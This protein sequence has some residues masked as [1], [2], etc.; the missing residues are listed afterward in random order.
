MPPKY[1]ISEELGKLAQRLVHLQALFFP[2]LNASPHNRDPHRWP[3]LAC[4]RWCLHDPRGLPIALALVSG[5]C[6]SRRL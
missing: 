3:R 5:R 2:G 1:R 6:P 4:A